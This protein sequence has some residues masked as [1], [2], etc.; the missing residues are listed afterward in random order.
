[1]GNASAGMALESICIFRP[2]KT[3]VGWY[4][5]GIHQFLTGFLEHRP[6]A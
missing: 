4:G 5:I 1:M 3:V 6:V 2:L